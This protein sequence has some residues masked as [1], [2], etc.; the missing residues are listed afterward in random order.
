MKRQDA[1]QIRLGQFVVGETELKI[2][3]RSRFVGDMPS[4]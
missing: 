1:E 4:E 3:I 2:R